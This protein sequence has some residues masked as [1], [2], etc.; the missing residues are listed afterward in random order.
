MREFTILY[1]EAELLATDTK[2]ISGPD[3]RRRFV[4]QAASH[5]VDVVGE[6]VARALARRS[7]VGRILSDGQEQT[8]SGRGMMVSGSYFPL[9]GIQPAL[10]RLFT[11]EDDRT[12]GGHP[13]VMRCP[14]IG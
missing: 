13:V 7:F 5:D 8:V 6:L 12:I 11:P 3:A 9:L 14:E 1:P 10:G 2:G 4:A